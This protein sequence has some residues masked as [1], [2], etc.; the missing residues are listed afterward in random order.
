MTREVFTSGRDHGITETAPRGTVQK[1]HIMTS[2][3]DRSARPAGQITTQDAIITRPGLRKVLAISRIVIGFTFLWAFL[4]KLFGL[5]YSTPAENA[6]ID[7]GSPH[8]DSSAASTTSPV[9]SSPFSR[10]P[11]AT[12][13]SCWAYWASAWP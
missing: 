1:G 4:D 7:G 9:D 10:T 13:S 3:L 5:Q 2:T 6:W 12:C 8:K 11:L